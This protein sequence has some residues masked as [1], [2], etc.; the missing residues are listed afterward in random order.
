MH[1]Y[2]LVKK[3]VDYENNTTHIVDKCSALDS[4]SKDSIETLVDAIKNLTKYKLVV[5]TVTDDEDSH[6]AVASKNG[7]VIVDQHNVV[8]ERVYIATA[9]S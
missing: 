6:I 1:Y 7:D 3:F 9:R 8:L 2:A 5:F 4:F